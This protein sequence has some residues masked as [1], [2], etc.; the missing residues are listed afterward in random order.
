V[1]QLVAAQLGRGEAVDVRYFAIRSNQ[2]VAAYCELFS[3]NEIGQIESVMTLKEFRGRGFGKAVVAR[4]L[5]ESKA[6]SHELT[7]LLADADDWPREFYRKLGFEEIGRVWDFPRE[8][9]S[10][11]TTGPSST[12]S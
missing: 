5:A 12:Q 4:A 1:R 3:R 8:P 11:G 2:Q 9:S 6:A 7:F 10:G